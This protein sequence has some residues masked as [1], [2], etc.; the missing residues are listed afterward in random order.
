MPVAQ[1]A[2][3]GHV[4]PAGGIHVLPQA[5]VTV[6]PRGGDYPVEEGG[7]DP[8]IAAD[9]PAPVAVAPPGIVVQIDDGPGRNHAD[10]ERIVPVL[11]SLG[12]VLPDQD[13]LPMR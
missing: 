7:D 9:G 4:G 2:D 5:G 11:T 8:R 3:H 6:T 1:R 10:P 13:R 12:A